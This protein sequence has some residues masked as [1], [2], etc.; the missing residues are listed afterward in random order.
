MFIDT[1]M[2][3]CTYSKDSYLKL[4]DMVKVAKRRGSVKWKYTA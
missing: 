4:E 2:H 3:E 1:H